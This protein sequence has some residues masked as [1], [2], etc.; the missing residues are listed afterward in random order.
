MKDN[1]IHPSGQTAQ[2][3]VNRLFLVPRGRRPDRK[4]IESDGARTR[5]YLRQRQA[6][7][8]AVNAMRS[9][10]GSEDGLRR[11]YIEEPVG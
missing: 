9:R 10:E 1:R 7:I 8:L 4:E 11:E 5:S 2:L 3:L 6:D